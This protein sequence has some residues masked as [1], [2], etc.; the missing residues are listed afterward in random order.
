L[1]GVERVLRVP[2]GG[3]GD[4]RDVVRRRLRRAQRLLG[5]VL[6][7]ALRL[8]AARRL[9]RRAEPLLGVSTDFCTF[10]NAPWAAFG[11]AA[12]DLLSAPLLVERAL[13]I[14]GWS[15]FLAPRARPSGP[16]AGLLDLLGDL[17]GLLR[18]RLHLLRG[19]GQVLSPARRPS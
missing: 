15:A 7:S 5:D 10:S 16:R 14:D 2:D 18:R 1:T 4:L 8:V 19:L 3:G 9:G 6:R 17:F 13:P 12:L 11:R